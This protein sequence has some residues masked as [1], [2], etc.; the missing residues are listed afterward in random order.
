MRQLLRAQAVGLDKDG[1]V[2]FVLFTGEILVLNLDY[3]NVIATIFGKFVVLLILK[4]VYG[5]R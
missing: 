4:L 5:S 1:L 2:L 3:L